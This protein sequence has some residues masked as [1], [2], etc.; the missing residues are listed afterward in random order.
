VED[1]MENVKNEI[2]KYLIIKAKV[3]MLQIKIGYKLCSK[4][5]VSI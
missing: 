3:G 1:E 2:R 5:N 4:K